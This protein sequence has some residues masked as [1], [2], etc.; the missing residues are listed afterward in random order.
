MRL[1]LIRSNNT[2]NILL[3]LIK[4]LPYHLSIREKMKF[5][6]GRNENLLRNFKTKLEVVLN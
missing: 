2:D 4:L 5:L 3:A 6:N 1:D